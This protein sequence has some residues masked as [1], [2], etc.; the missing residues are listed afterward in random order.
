MKATR[1]FSAVIMLS[2]FLACSLSAKVSATSD[3]HMEAHS[4]NEANDYLAD[5]SL[6]NMSTPPRYGETPEDSILC[7]RNISLYQE[8]WNQGNRKLAFEPWREVFF[9]CPQASLNT[10]IRGVHLIKMKY[11]EET[12]PIR[13]DAWVDT[14]ML[15][16][17]KRIEYFGHMPQSRKGAVLGRKAVDLYQLRPNNV[18]EIF[19]MTARSIELEGDNTQADA[20]LI[21]M[22]SLIRLVE[23]GVK[24]EAEILD[25]YDRIMNIIDYNLEHN[26]G[27]A[28]LYEPAKSNIEIMFDPFATCDNIKALYGPRFKNNPE[29]IELLEKVT[30]MLNKQGCT[31]TELFYKATLN[32]HR[33]KP[34][35]Q[36]AFLM[37][38]MERDAQN[39]NEAIRY[40]GQAV[41]LYEKSEDKFTALMLMADITYR[42]LRQFPQARTYA[43]RAA[44]HD[45]NNGRPYL[46]IG[47]MYAASASQCGDNDLTRTVAYWAAVDKFV[48]ARN[49]D[50]D[51][52]VQERATQL[53]NTYRQHYPSREVTFFY[54]LD[55]GDT[56]RVECWINETTTVRS[57]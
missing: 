54:G 30:S 13:R 53:I 16:Y 41:D 25:T 34:T 31:D 22:Q 35:A 40:Y 26:P 5:A 11:S 49:V 20:L 47:E 12:D 55:D 32:L 37:A 15:L 33:L 48:Q 17:D 2:L 46:L 56:Y 45:P 10:F 24:D 50:Q 38:R 14:L 43:L 18:Q 52:L 51:P 29:N 21:H 39:F 3:M 28:R 27:E 9:N 4:L 57:R 1:F 6:N 7:V 19:D 42:Q 44:N 23:A 8:Y 36:S